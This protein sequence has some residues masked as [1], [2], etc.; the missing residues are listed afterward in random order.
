MIRQGPLLAAPFSDM[1]DP[2]NLDATALAAALGQRQMS[3][4]EV[5]TAFL[6]RIEAINPR[7]NAIVALRPRDELLAE[8]EAADNAPRKG[9]LHGIPFAVKDLVETAG[10]LTTHGSPIFADH[11]PE[12]DDLL[13]ARLRAVG[14]IFIGK[15]NT[16]EFGLGSHSFNPVHGVTRNPYDLSRTAGGS[17]GGAAAALATRLVP[18]AD[19]SDAMGSLRNP[20]AFCNVYGFRPSFGRVPRDV[21]GDLFLHQLATDGPM[22]RTVQDLARLLDTLSGPDPRDPHALPQHAPFAADLGVSVK[23]ARIG[24]V[25]DWAGR[26]P[27]EPGIVELCQPALRQFESMGVDVEPVVADFDPER[28]WQSWLTLRSFSNAAGKRAHYEDA[29]KRRLLKPEL[30]YEIERGLTLSAMQV[31]DASVARTD[32]FA[33]AADL[34]DT[35]DVL[36]LP[37]AQVFPF[38]AD[39]RWPKTVAGREMA[40]YHQWMEIVLP[41]SLAGLPA[42]NVPVGFS[43]EGLPMGMQLIGRRGADLRVL[44]IGEAYHQATN[45][46]QKMPP[47]LD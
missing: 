3:C 1:S 14:A 41:A 27:I 43:P 6:D 24:W 9:W 32:W 38:D 23:G 34:F 36:A 22:A 16:P 25:G 10:I 40:T 18:V 42:L 8:A 26:Y 21:E 4:V 20:A 35:Y 39:L 37:S 47:A 17:S 7:I 5:M 31:H 11:V 13:A 12:K 29:A 45:W 28:L 15:T 2:T 44:Q 19:G 33:C 30:I 46:P